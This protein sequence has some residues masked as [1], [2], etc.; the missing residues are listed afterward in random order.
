MSDETKG[1]PLPSVRPGSRP[2]EAE[3][4]PSA[5]LALAAARGDQQA[6]AQLYERFA[7]M[8]HAI[9]V[10]SGPR[11][12][13]QDGTQE[14]FLSAL[15]AIDQLDEPDRIGGWLATIARNKARDLHRRGLPVENADLE[16]V[17]ENPAEPDNSEEAELVLS[18][19]RELPESYRE[20][21]VMRLVE[22][23]TGPE[24]AERTGMTHGSVR[25]N[26]HRGMKLLKERLARLGFEGMAE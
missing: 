12:M 18:A 8:V 10:A 13:D 17:P 9:L 3:V 5:E 6:F 23:L 16:F 1:G 24:I 19:V 15:G 4:P 7:P 20:T 26:L 25:V 22:G 2:P 21:L 11:G 14:V